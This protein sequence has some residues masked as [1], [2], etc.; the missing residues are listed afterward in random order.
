MSGDN[1]TVALFLIDAA[2]T[3]IGL[4]ISQAGWK[5]PVLIGSV[6]VLGVACLFGGVFW[7]FVKGVSP[8][9]VVDSITKIGTNPESWFFLFIMALIIWIVPKHP[10]QKVVFHTSQK[11][12]TKNQLGQSAD[13]LAGKAHAEAFYDKQETSEEKKLRVFTKR[14]PSDLISV[15][16]S[17]TGIQAEI[18]LRPNIGQWIEVKG[19]V[20]AVNRTG[21]LDKISVFLL[22]AETNSDM[23]AVC[24]FSKDWND[25]LISLQKHDLVAIRGKIKTID[26][27]ISL[28]N[29]EM[30]L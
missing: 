24:W 9:P 3:L 16:K 26:S 30:D 14:T 19:L 15:Y 12:E 18:L 29:C 2:I 25:K 5:H 28:V 7:P 13:F 23:Q 4:G 22:G 20:F 17:H 21:A 6:F 8:T 11:S 1:L 27:G 10:S